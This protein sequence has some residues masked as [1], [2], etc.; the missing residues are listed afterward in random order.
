MQHLQPNTTLQG[1]KYRKL[2]VSECQKNLFLI[3]RA[4]AGYSIA[5]V[6]GQQSTGI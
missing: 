5:R 1:G 2:R 4:R 6:L 3:D